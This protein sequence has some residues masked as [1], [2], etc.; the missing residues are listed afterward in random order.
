MRLNSLF[1]LV[2]EPLMCYCFAGGSQHPGASL[3]NG[4]SRRTTQTSIV[5]DARLAVWAMTAEPTP[6]E[7]KARG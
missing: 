2:Y 1:C 3:E 5:R 4:R 7:R 6:D